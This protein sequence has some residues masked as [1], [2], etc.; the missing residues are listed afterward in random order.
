[1]ESP[2]I[3]IIGLDALIQ[4]IREAIR[5]ARFRKEE[6]EERQLDVELKRRELELKERS[7][8]SG[9]RR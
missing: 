6:R 1:M 9:N 7:S 3:S 5:D 8:S 2:R 4:Q